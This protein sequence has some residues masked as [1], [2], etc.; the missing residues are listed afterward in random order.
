VRTTG[1]GALLLVAGSPLVALAQ[2]APTKPDRW[3][4]LL[5]GREGALAKHDL[6]WIP[7]VSPPKGTA[8][9]GAK[10]VSFLD[11]AQPVDRAQLRYLGYE[12]PGSQAPYSKVHVLPRKLQHPHHIYRYREFTILT[13]ADGAREQLCVYA[14]ARALELLRA[15][16]PREFEV[17]FRGPKRAADQLAAILRGDPKK[18][19]HFLNID[20]AHTF[21]WQGRS[22]GAIAASSYDLGTRADLDLEVGPRRLKLGLFRNVATTFLNTPA[23]QGFRSQKIYRRAALEENFLRYLRDGL[24]ETLVH[25][26]LHNLLRRDKN[27]RPLFWALTESLRKSES[28]S[29]GKAVEEV[30]VS[31][32]AARLLAEHGLSREVSEFYGKLRLAQLRRL[33]GLPGSETE[34]GRRLLGVLRG[35]RP[36]TRTWQDLFSFEIAPKPR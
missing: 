30:F 31:N 9:R 11:S 26:A 18:S 15:R 14:T 6:S 13:E 4:P 10:P 35:L 7:R 19:I 3:A 21:V 28:S 20:R 12:L 24:V 5:E 1:L 2:E 25:E 8:K 22:G 34:S 32:V 23:I 29:I 36:K 16:W 17:L 33:G 27:V